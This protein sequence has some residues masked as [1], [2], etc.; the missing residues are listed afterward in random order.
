M[1][2]FSKCGAEIL[3]MDDWFA[4]APPKK[5]EKHWLDNRSA[6]EM[7]RYWL[8]MDSVRRTAIAVS[9]T[10]AFGPIR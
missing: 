1:I 2:P 5:G 9:R 4:L 3:T 6:K 7:A 8:S 10:G